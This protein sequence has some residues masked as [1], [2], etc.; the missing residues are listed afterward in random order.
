MK[1]NGKDNILCRNEGRETK[2][3]VSIPGIRIE[4]TIHESA[5]SIVLRGTRYPG[6]QKVIVKLPAGECFLEL[7][8]KT[9]RSPKAMFDSLDMLASHGPRPYTTPE[10][11]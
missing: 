11:F 6:S 2:A 7:A 4:G 1:D 5:N 10:C 9:G 8:R 3:V